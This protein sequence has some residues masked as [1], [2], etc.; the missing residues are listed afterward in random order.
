M[1]VALQPVVRGPRTRTWQLV[2]IA[3]LTA[4]SMWVES[5]RLLPAMPRERRASFCLGLGLGLIVSAVAGG[6]VGYYLTAGLPVVLAAGLLFLTPLS[7]LISVT[8]NSKTLVER[9][10]F[11]LGFVIA[12]LLAAYKIELDLLW[13]GIVGG[14]LGF[15]AHRLREAWRRE[16]P[17]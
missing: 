16:T 17:R 14:T 12:P 15:A 10:A 8:R 6:F 1:V 2:L 13:T 7:F 11:G 5:L 9:I 4:I 3:H